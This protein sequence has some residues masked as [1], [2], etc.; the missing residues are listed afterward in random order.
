MN[1]IYW[2]W[3]D[4]SQVFSWCSWRT[5]LAKLG[6][7]VKLPGVSALQTSP[8]A[9]SCECDDSPS[10]IVRCGLQVAKHDYCSSWRW[11]RSLSIAYRRSWVADPSWLENCLI[12]LSLWR[13]RSS[14]ST[15]G[16]LSWNFAHTLSIPSPWQLS[17]HPLRHQEHQF[18]RC[19]AKGY[20]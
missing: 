7:E 8:R 6:V 1:Q 9:Q 15:R 11:Q 12:F 19:D 20:P 2:E 17:W 4:T 3:C 16:P 5:R 14:K 13:A 10:W 18:H